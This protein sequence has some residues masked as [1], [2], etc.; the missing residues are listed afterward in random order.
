MALFCRIRPVPQTCNRSAHRK[1]QAAI[2]RNVRDVR[3]CCTA[4]IRYRTNLVR[5]GRLGQDGYRVRIRWARYRCLELKWSILDNGQTVAQ[6]VLQ[7]YGGVWREI[8]NCSADRSRNRIRRATD[9]DRYDVRCCR[10]GTAGDSAGLSR[11][12]G[13]RGN[14]YRVGLATCNLSWKGECRGAGRTGKLFPPLS[15]NVKPVPTRF[16]TV[17]PIE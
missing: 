14:C 1:A 2:D 15:S 4:S 11:A 17:P 16:E 7:N 10:A 8:G 12:R 6:I 3:S 13:L 5:R 9:A